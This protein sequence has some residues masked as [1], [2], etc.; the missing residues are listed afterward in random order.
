MPRSGYLSRYRFPTS[1][2]RAAIVLH[3]FMPS[4]AVP[5]ILFLFFRANVSYKTVCDWTQKFRGTTILPTVTYQAGS[6]L[7]CHADEKY[8]RVAH[9][10][11][12]LWSLKDHL[13]NVINWLL[14]RTRDF[15]SAKNLLKAGRRKLG[16]DADLLVRDG[17]PAYNRATKFLGRRCKSIVAGIRGTNI[18]H[19]KNLYHLTNNPSESLNSEIDAYLARFQYNFSDIESAQRFIDGFM[20]T[21]HLKKSFAEKRFSEASS[22]LNQAISI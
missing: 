16:K 6:A 5:V 9:E 11:H 4:R 21:K 14:T 17:L 13:G 2:I 12:Y 3:L 1:V 18:L 19:N 22:M 7:V 10:W 15:A 20:L 8:V